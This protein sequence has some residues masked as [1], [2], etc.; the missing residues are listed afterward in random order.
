MTE[1]EEAKLHMQLLQ[2]AVKNKTGPAEYG[3]PELVAIEHD[4]YDAKHVGNAA[5]ER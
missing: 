1:V 3:P 2:E 5:E 4:E